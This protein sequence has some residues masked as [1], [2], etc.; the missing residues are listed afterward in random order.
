MDV[1]SEEI[2]NEE[3]WKLLYTDDVVIT[4]ENEEDLQRTV[5]KW[6][7]S[8][9][10]GGLKVNVNKT[11]VLLSSREDGDRI[12]IQE[13]RGLNIKQAEKFRY[14]GSTLSQEGGCEAEVDSSIKAVW[15]KW[16]EV[17]GVVCDKKMPIKMK[18]KMYSTVIRPVLMYG[19]ETW[20]LRRK[21]DVKLERTDMRMLR[22][23]IGIPLLHRLE[24]DEIRRAGL[25]KITEVIRESCDKEYM[26]RRRLVEDDVFDRKQW[27]RRIR[28][29]TP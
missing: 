6:Q 3:L 4:A 16:R 5:G 18:V 2:R 10:R 11:E 7:K 1:L 23:I 9:E 27:R 25:V 19:A 14:I 21:E 17:A 15:G 13:R 22:L 20:D 12:V 28:Q 29:P 26:E 8:L 24:N